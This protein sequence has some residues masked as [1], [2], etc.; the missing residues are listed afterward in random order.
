VRNLLLIGIAAGASAAF[1]PTHPQSR[2]PTLFLETFDG[3][4][5]SPQPWQPADWDVTIHSRDPS[6]W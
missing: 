1:A 2:E 5:A 3:S 6:T 4:P